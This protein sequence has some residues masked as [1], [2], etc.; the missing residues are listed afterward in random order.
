M[1]LIIPHI[2][3]KVRSWLA[4][5]NNVLIQY[6]INV[7]T[8]LLLQGIRT[9]KWLY[10]Y[11]FC[12]FPIY[13]VDKWKV[14]NAR[15]QNEA[16][17]RITVLS[18]ASFSLYLS[19][20]FAI[21]TFSVFSNSLSRTSSSNRTICLKTSHSTKLLGRKKRKHME[22]KH[23]EDRSNVSRSASTF[24]TLFN[25]NAPT[26]TINTPVDDYIIS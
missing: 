1:S 10:K 4:W 11:I 23:V 25:I 7:I 26:H 21:R 13:T 17:H 8:G 2:T 12:S 3:W 14:T 15:K 18:M 22:E 5:D 20:S 24:V 9:D 6:F 19:C 16:N